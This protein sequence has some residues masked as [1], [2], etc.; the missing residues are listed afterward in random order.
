[1]LDALNFIVDLFKS[2]GNLIKMFVSGLA[3]CYAMLPSFIT[4]F[5]ESIGYLPAVLAYFATLAVTLMV[6]NYIIGRK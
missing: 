1:M 5:F 2:L 4:S 6:L 3:T